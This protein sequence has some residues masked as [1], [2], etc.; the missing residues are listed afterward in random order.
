VVLTRAAQS[1]EVAALGLLLEQH[2]AGM[3]AVALSILGPGPDADD[4][5]QDA[6]L[7]A[8]RG[9]GDVR[10]PAA[11]GAWLRM[12][13]R[14][15]CRDMKRAARQVEPYA[16]VPRPRS[17]DR[18][19]GG[20]GVGVGATPEDVLDRLAM[21]DWVW[22]A[23]EQLSPTLRLPVVL[24]YFTEGVSGYDRIAEVCGVP[25]GTVRSRLNQA[26][27]K[28]ADALAATTAEA[29]SDARVRTRASWQEAHHTLAAAEAGDFGKVISRRWSPELSMM[30]GAT[31]IGDGALI[32]DA[33]DVSLAAGVRQRPVNVAA[34]RSVAVWEMDM[35]NPTDDPEHCPAA[36]AWIMS[37]DGGRVS[38]LRLVHPVPLDGPATPDLYALT[39]KVPDV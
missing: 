38:Q 2:R 35:I 37:L 16:V 9:I 36:L 27:G 8:L 21:R 11:V 23:L 33:M 7:I 13:V 25:V 15:R 12:I 19:G 39:Q 31:R 26:R 10:D 14:N 28:L 18:A 17:E 24:R 6:A 4:A 3:R 32:R 30:T 1:G 20:A 29:H 5:V 22:E 34:G